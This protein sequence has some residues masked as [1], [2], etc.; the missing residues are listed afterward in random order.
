MRIETIKSK[1]PPPHT[2]ETPNHSFLYLAMRPD[3]PAAASPI[4]RPQLLV[5]GRRQRVLQLLELA[6]AAFFWIVLG[7]LYV[8]VS[9][10]SV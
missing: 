8:C 6:E 10:G 2:H 1:H 5:L 4:V 9:V 7:Y 3:E